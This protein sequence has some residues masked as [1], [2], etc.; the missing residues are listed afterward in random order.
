MGILLFCTAV[1]FV[2]GAVLFAN[3][4]SHRT[5]WERG[6][7][8]AFYINIPNFIFLSYVIGPNYGTDLYAFILFGLV[9]GF[10]FGGFGLDAIAGMIF[11]FIR[12]N[13]VRGP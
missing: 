13:S 7:G 5:K 8:L 11:V 3:V 4:F 12:T 6:I 2:I 10:G 9:E 1:G